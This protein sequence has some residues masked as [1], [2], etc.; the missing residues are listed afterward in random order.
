MSMGGMI[1]RTALGVLVAGG[2]VSAGA[3]YLLRRPVPK[4]KGR[5]KLQGLR[6][7]V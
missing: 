4:A 7:E 3:Y 2:A 6:A 5:L 1:R